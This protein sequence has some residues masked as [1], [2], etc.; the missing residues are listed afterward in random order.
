MANIVDLAEIA[1]ATD[2][3][4]LLAADVYPLIAEARKAIQTLARYEPQ[5]LTRPDRATTNNGL[6]SV[7]DAGRSRFVAPPP[8]LVAA[9]REG[10]H[11]G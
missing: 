4:Q 2:E 1:N 9:R 7:L 11:A 3:T 8:S 5:Q 6:P 10:C